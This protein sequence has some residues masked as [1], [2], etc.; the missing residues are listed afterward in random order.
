MVNLTDCYCPHKQ[1]IGSVVPN[2]LMKCRAISPGAKLC[3]GRLAQFAGK[4][5]YA[6]PGIDTLA[7]ELGVSEATAKNYLAELR[8]ERLIAS[9]RTGNGN[10]SRHY[11][12]QHPMIEYRTDSQ[13]HSRLNGGQTANNPTPDSQKHSRPI[14]ENQGRESQ[15]GRESEEVLNEEVCSV[16]T[17]YAFGRRGDNPDTEDGSYPF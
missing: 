10:V 5:L 14:K 3:F 11:F 8:A 4:A 7:A 17:S 13:K 1:F 12:L 6:Y 9:E 16:R 2:W 15:R